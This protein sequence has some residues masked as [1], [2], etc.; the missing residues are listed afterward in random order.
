MKK[1]ITVA[2]SLQINAFYRFIGNKCVYITLSLKNK[3]TDLF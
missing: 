1:I 2:F 3:F